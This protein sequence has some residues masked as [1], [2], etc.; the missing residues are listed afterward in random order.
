MSEPIKFKFSS[1]IITNIKAK[2]D[3][4]K[5][6]EYS[7]PVPDP[8]SYQPSGKIDITYLYLLTLW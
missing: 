6:T 8:E 1:D 7:F 2:E 5:P 4:S 3:N